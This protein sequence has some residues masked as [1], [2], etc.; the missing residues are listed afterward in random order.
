MYG[1]QWAKIKSG[2]LDKMYKNKLEDED[3][4][5]NYLR[6][7]ILLCNNLRYFLVLATQIF[8]ILQ[9]K[10]K[11]KLREVNIQCILC[12]E[13]LDSSHTNNIF[14]VNKKFSSCYKNF[15]S[16]FTKII[17]PFVIFHHR[18]G[19][20]NVNVIPELQS[21]HPSRISEATYR[22]IINNGGE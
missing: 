9:Q 19:G 3:F 14:I 15:Q 13:Y 22:S 6:F 10:H 16:R 1:C 12:N 20:N 21:T 2:E 11:Q 18:G 17:V 8:T 7:E 4:N 5:D